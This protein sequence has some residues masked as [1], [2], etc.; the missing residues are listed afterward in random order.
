[1]LPRIVVA[2]A[3]LAVCTLLIASI[4]PRPE[5][6]ETVLVRS[7]PLRVALEAEGIARVRDRYVVTA[8]VA[9]RLARSTLRDGDRVRAG[10]VVA[11]IDPFT[12]RTAIDE[13]QA[14]IDQARAQRR[15]VPAAVP[16][17]ETL[18]QAR[19]R[20][21]AARHAQA[22]T[23]SRVRQADAA[24]AQAARDRDRASALAASGDLARSASEASGLNAT[25]RA[26]DAAAARVAS[27]AAAADVDAARAA[28]A[29]LGAKQGDAASLYAAYDAQI[30]GAE[31]ALRRLRDE[32]ARTAVR[33]PVSGR[34]LRVLQT[35]AASVD[36]GAP[37]LELADTRALELV[38]DVLSTDAAGIA[39]GAAVRVVRGAGERVL[40]ARVRSVG[41]TATTKTSALGVEEQRVDVI[42]D[43]LDAPHALGDRYR[44]EGEIDQW[45][46]PA[47]TQI[48]IG[49]LVRCDR[50][51]CAYVVTA[52]RAHRRVL[53]LGHRNEDA[54]EVRA[55]LRRGERVVV[56]PDERLADGARVALAAP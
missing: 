53:A 20:L 16:R 27:E 14:R 55:G 31:A 36:A 29:E 43:L 50:D 10:Q 38:F 15:G 33:A 30:A 5:R 4:R 52:G 2:V 45:S 44:V 56:H 39:P 23:I 40:R 12:L 13:A 41:A 34:V 47:V 32:A 42:A 54:A 26:Q 8:P 22:Q 6:V 28:L 48:P 11:Q 25:L 24:A 9:G 19:A 51:W 17:S 3:V 49:A 35:S 7:A 1:M 46:S 37:L 21:D 18:A